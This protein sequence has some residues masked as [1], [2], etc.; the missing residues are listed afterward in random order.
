MATNSIMSPAPAWLNMS[1]RTPTMPSAPS[2]AAS[3]SMRDMA[4]CRA[5]DM[6]WVRAS[7]SWLAG[8]RCT[9]RPRWYI[10]VPMTSEIGLNPHSLMSANSLTVR[11]LV[12]SEPGPRRAV[13]ARR[14]AAVAGRLD[15]GIGS[16]MS[17]SSY[18]HSGAGATGMARWRARSSGPTARPVTRHPPGGPDVNRSPRAAGGTP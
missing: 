5:S 17:D 3:A 9:S 16:V 7:S 2:A 8:H 15:G 13:A 11:S 1:R 6:A 12:N 14:A 10:A 4:S 18:P